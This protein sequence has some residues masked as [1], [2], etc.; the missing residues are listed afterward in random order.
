M[1]KTATD[2]K[3]VIMG[4]SNNPERYSHKAAMRLKAAGFQDVVGVNP[5]KPQLPGIEVVA[6]LT[7]VAG[8]IDTITLYL[9][10]NIVDG[11][12]DKIVAAHP[13]RIIMN[14]GAEHEKLAE[15]AKGAGILVEQAC[16]LV[17]LA[18]SSF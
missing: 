11:M 16:T 6:D 7:Q 14:P 3:I 10:P 17:L 15:T 18:T 1:Q 8:A 12:V 5:S 13:R 2:A 9:S 4:I